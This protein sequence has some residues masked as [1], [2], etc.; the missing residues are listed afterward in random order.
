MD[1]RFGFS[2]STSFGSL[3]SLESLGEKSPGVGEL[4]FAQSSP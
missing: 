2:N 4:P 1:R 3:S